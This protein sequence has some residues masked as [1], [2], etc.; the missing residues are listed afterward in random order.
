M[1]C[2]I[3]LSVLCI[4]VAAVAQS[5]C[6]KGNETVSN[7]KKAIIGETTASAKYAAYAQKAKEDKLDKIAL[8]F[9]AAS[10]AEAIHA[11]N[12]RDVLEA[13]NVKMDSITP[14][15][16]VKTTKENLED[17]IKGETY[18][19][20]TMYPEF[21]KK[22]QE[23]KNKDAIT[24][25]DYAFQVEKT[26]KVLYTTALQALNKNDM[27]TLPDSYTVCLICGETYGANAPVHC[28]ICDTS[29]ADFIVFK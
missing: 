13:C 6:K 23:E 1:K 15:F 4:A 22:A 16:T 25:F 5:E 11:K 14:K 12:H 2:K 19:V 7:L 26:H 20:T 21:I 28:K 10:K 18:E 3:L 9:E 29:N 17:A 8:L 24:T 27:K